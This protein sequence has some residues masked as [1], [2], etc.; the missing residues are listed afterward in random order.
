[1]YAIWRLQQNIQHLRMRNIIDI[2][3][4]SRIGEICAYSERER[5]RELEKD[6]EKERRYFANKT[7]LIKF[8]F[9]P[10]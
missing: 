2:C 9:L 7:N 5:E 1:M 10:P 6:E 3:A 4:Y 8:F